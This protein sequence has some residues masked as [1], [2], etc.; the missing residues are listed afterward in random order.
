MLLLPSFRLAGAIRAETPL[1]LEFP[2][3]PKSE[4]AVLLVDDDSSVRKGISRVLIAEG[5]QVVTARCVKDALECISRE[6]PDLVITDLCMAP[7]SGWDLMVHLNSRYPA[8]PVFVV[9]ALPPAQSA[10]GADHVADAFF[11]KPLNLEALLAAI[12]TQFGMP[13][14]WQSLHPV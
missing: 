12:R 4:P 11:Q 9:T 13:G 2:V 10:G 5:L 14:A 8:L 1:L 6:I 7:L 3:T